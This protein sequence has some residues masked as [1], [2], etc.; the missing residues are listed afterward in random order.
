MIISENKKNLSLSPYQGSPFP[1]S[2][3]SWRNGGGGSGARG[4]VKGSGRGERRERG[5]RGDRDRG[6]SHF[7]LVESE[8]EVVEGVRGKGKRRTIKLFNSYIKKA[9][10]RGG[11]GE[12]RGEGGEGGQGGKGP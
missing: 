4:T 11:Y 8:D 6:R 10:G 9:G 5:G 7:L 2:S 12:G 3:F 1:P